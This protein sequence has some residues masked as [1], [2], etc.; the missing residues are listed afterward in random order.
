[1]LPFYQ[2]VCGD[3]LANNPAQPPCVA[4]CGQGALEYREVDSHEPDVYLLETH[5]AARAAKW[6]KKEETA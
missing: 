3:C 1:M 6:V 2:T 5:L 4:S